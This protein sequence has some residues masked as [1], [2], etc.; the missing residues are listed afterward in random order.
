M[1]TRHEVLGGKVQVY[2]RPASPHWQCSAS[3]GGRQYRISSKQE[4]LSQA[5]DFA[6]DWYL[7]LKGKDRFGG[8]LP[9]GKTKT[10]RQAAQIFLTEYKALNSDQRNPKYIGNMEGKIKNY[11]NPF[12][13]DMPVT[14]ITEAQIVKYR[15]ERLKV[16]E[17]DAPSAESAGAKKDRRAGP[18]PNRPSRSTLHSEII[19]FGHVMQTAKRIGWIAAVPSYKAPYQASSKISHRAWFSLEEYRTLREAT[20]K[21]AKQPPNP[22]WKWEC[23]QLHDYILFMSNT[24]LRP[25]EARRLEFRDV[26][27]VDDDD[28]EERILEIDVRGKRGVGYCKS[29]PGAVRPFERIRDRLRAVPAEPSPLTRDRRE[30]SPARR[31]RGTAPER[32][33]GNKGGF[34]RGAGKSMV[35]PGPMDRLFPAPQAELLNAVLAELSLKFDRDGQRRTA[36]SLRHTYICFRLMEGADIYQIA[37]NCRTSVEMIEKYYASHIKHMLDAAAINVRKVKSDKNKEVGTLT[38]E[39]D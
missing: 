7:S 19:T 24:G 26:V 33:R 36:Y 25:D 2:R 28:T 8:G 32:E 6:E 20:K 22:K 18:K 35:K 14:T 38:A 10:F 39:E 5:K 12:F 13:G 30:K 17:P 11:L 23:E 4:G 15:I 29:M 21:R 1:T 3:I 27:I 31:A 9:L 37:K 34:S 16:P